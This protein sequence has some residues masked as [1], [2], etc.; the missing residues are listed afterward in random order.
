MTQ[1]KPTIICV[2]DEEIVRSSL[3]EQLRR[4]FGQHFR[5]EAVEDAEAALELIE[6]LDDP[7]REL[8]LIIADQIMPGLKGDELLVELHRRHPKTLSILLTGQASLE[9]VANAVNRASLY[10]YISKPWE[11]EDLNL[12]V[13]E[14]LRRYVQDRQLDEQNAELR[15]LNASLAHKAEAFFRFVPKD[16]LRLL[17]AQDRYESVHLGA[18]VDIDLA[19]MFTDIRGFTTMAETMDPASCVAFVNEYLSAIEPAIADNGGFIEHIAGDGILALFDQG[20]EKAIRAAL[21]IQERLAQ[22]NRTR[23]EAGKAAIETGM[24][25]NFGRLTLG[26]LGSSNRLKCGVVGDP[27]NLTAR[28]EGLTALYGCSILATETVIAALPEGEPFTSRHVDLVVVKG[29]TTAVSA[30]EI[31]EALPEPTRQVRLRTLSTYNAA[32]AAFYAGRMDEAAS[33]FREVLAQD[34]QDHHARRFLARSEALAV[35]GLPAGW[36]GAI[37][38][39]HK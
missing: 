36:T 17:G 28:L 9:A 32:C 26:T 6:E 20:A 33:L 12:T 22:F 39:S 15:A 37:V 21:Q 16:F 31:L 34:P 14:A 38:L 11:R 24:G 25:I 18:S 13:R 23:A 30:V 27:V 19:V 4:D 5:I 29:R 3:R 35:D 7:E 10:R 8:P 1:S 2:D